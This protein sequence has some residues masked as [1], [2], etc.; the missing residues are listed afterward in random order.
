M[1]ENKKYPTGTVVRDMYNL[2]ED[3]F[4][5]PCY[6]KLENGNWAYGTQLYFTIK[7]ESIGEGKRFKVV[8]IPTQ[9]KVEDNSWDE[10]QKKFEVY[11]KLYPEIEGSYFDF[12]AWAKTQHYTLIKK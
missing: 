11:C 6:T 12:I 9:P 3:E 8:S 7:D 2:A 5:K 10:A 4:D 1:T